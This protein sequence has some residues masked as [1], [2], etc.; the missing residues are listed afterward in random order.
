[1][2]IQIKNKTYF[3]DNSKRNYKSFVI[4]NY[5]LLLAYKNN[6]IKLNPFFKSLFIKRTIF[7]FDLSRDNVSKLYT[8][9]RFM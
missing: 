8:L 3:F 6:T 9:M 1:M 5:F 2:Q 4:I 7:I